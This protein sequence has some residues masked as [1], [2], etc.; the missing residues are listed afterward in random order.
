MIEGEPLNILYKLVGKQNTPKKRKL[1][2]IK[3]TVHNIK[4]VIIALN[5]YENLYYQFL[6]FANLK[7]REQ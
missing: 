1:A 5:S 4:V 2:I 3:L 7:M 6:Y